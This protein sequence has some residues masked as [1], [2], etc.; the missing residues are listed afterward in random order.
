MLRLDLTSPAGAAI[1]CARFDAPEALAVY[2]AGPVAAY[3]TDRWGN[4][5]LSFYGEDAATT[6][7]RA[8]LGD[9]DRVAASDALLDRMESA[10]GFEARRW[11][12]INAVAGG[13]PNVAAHL[14]GS[15][16]AMRR[17]VRAMDAAAP[18][19]IAIEMTVSA[20][21]KPAEIARR[22]AAALAL[23]RIAAAARPVTLWAYYGAQNDGL[24]AAFAVRIETAPLDLARA[25]WLL[26]SPEACRRA[27]LSICCVVGGWPKNDGGAQWLRNHAATMSAILPTLTGA[28]D[29]VSV[30]GLN[31]TEGREAFASDAAAAAWV[32]S[33]L[34]THGAVERAA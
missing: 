14:A 10:V 18:L 27:A 25:A 34:A 6:L 15:P 30:A 31:T 32:A 23:T 13:A 7:H 26:C 29:F 9:V 19:T 2:L 11:R 22:G 5:D 24:N 20:N 28:T 21:A 3:G 4:G 17:R 12:T 16:M 8:L 1:P 33:M